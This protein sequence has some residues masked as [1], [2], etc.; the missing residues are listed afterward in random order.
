MRSS[1][2]EGPK[3]GDDRDGDVG[4]HHHLEQLDETVG[5]PFRPRPAR[6]EEPEDSPGEPD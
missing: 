5:G 1:E 6:E 2:L 4:Q 3:T